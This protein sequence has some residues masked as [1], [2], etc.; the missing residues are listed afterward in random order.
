[1][2]AATTDLNIAGYN[3]EEFEAGPDILVAAAFREHLKAIDPQLDCIWVK[4]NARNFPNPGRWHIVRW[5]SNPE[6]TCYWVVQDEKGDYCEP[7]EFHLQRLMAIDS[8]TQ[9]R[10]R[11]IQDARNSRATKRRARVEETRREF[12]E[13]LMDRLDHLANARVHIP[14]DI[15]LPDRIEVPQPGGLEPAAKTLALPDGS[16]L[17]I[18]PAPEEAPHGIA[19]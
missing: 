16:E 4:P 8:R 11:Q 18:A 6:L 3:R 13:K 15:V 14:R 10:M 7:G 5:H 1:M 12:R 17:A 9:D 2:D 19:R